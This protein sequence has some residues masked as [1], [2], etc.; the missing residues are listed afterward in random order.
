MSPQLQARI[1]AAIAEGIRKSNENWA[2]MELAMEEAEEARRIKQADKL[3]ELE[4]KREQAVEDIALY[5][6][7]IEYLNDV[8]GDWESAKS[9]AQDDIAFYEAQARF[10]PSAMRVGVLEDCKKAERK[11][12]AEIIKLKVKIRTAGRKLEQARMVKASAEAKLTA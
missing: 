9:K 7:Q 6:E 2:A 1:D 4:S 5:K 12:S 10:A 8:L 11:A 3:E